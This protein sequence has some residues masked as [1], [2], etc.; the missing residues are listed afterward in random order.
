MINEM[1]TL[2]KS[3]IILP[4]MRNLCLKAHSLISAMALSPFSNPQGIVN[5]SD[6]SRDLWGQM[7][8]EKAN[9]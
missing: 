7:V 8:E 4:T 1:L 6:T 2:R 5:M 3:V 9:K